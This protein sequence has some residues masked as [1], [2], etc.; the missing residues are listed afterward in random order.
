MFIMAINVAVSGLGIALLPRLLIDQELHSGKL[1]RIGR[2][3]NRGAAAL[4]LSFPE[5]KRE[6]ASLTKFITGIESAVKD[7]KAS[8]D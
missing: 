7:Y 8:F 3:V 4:Y 6:L 2:Y 5:Q 1:V